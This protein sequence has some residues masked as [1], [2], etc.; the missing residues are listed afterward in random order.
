MWTALS[1]NTAR[2][3]RVQ[4]QSCGQHYQWTQPGYTGY[5]CSH[6]DSIISEHGQGTHGTGAVMRT[7][8]SVN[9]ARVHMVQVQ[10]CG[11]HYQW[12]QPGYTWYRCSHVDNIISEHSQGTHGT[13]AVMWTALSVNTA[14]VH[15]VQVQSCGQHY[16]WTQPGYTWYRCSHVDSI[17]SEH[18]QGTHGTG[19]VMWTALSVNTARVHMVQVQSWGQHYQWTQPGYTWYRCSHVDSII[20]EHSQG[21]HGTGAVMWTALSVNTARVHMVQ[22]QSCGQHYQ[23]TQPGYTWYSCSHVDSIISEQSQGAQRTGAVMW[24]AL[25]VNT[26]RVHMVQVQSCGQHNRIW[27]ACF[28]YEQPVKLQGETYKFAFRSSYGNTT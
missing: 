5:R 11:Q 8:L 12:T 13:G 19:A 17:I 24:T 20:S 7:A 21:T 4:V 1:V 25:S 10:S 23:W 3:H 26:A 22:V 15:I 28:N 18:S 27:N 16:Q 6:V 2:V 9:T 14:R